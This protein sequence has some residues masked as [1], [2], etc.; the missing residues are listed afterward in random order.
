MV[1]VRMERTIVIQGT[2]WSLEE[3][4]GSKLCFAWLFSWR[5]K[6]GRKRKR[7]EESKKE[8]RMLLGK[9]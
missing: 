7:G 6:G 8:S 9:A 2:E 4:P 1:T 3:T 5:K